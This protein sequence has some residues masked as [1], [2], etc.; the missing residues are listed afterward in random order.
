LRRGDPLAGITGTAYLGQDGA[1]QRL[2]QRALSREELRDAIF[3]TPY[4]RMPYRAY[5]ERLAETCAVG[6][7]PTKAE[8]EARL[9]EIRSVRL[10]TLNYCPMGCTFCSS[11][12][13]LHSAQEGTARLA[14]LTAEECV[15]ML[16]RILAAHPDARTLI[17]QD[18]IFAFRNDARLL[19]LCEALTEC[20]RRVEIPE[21]FSF[22]STNRIDAMTDE[23]LAAMRGAGFR[24]LGFGV[25]NFSA[26]VLQEF[27]K[28]QIR[29]HI[30]PVLESALRLGITPFL[31][32]IL[33]SPRC[34]LRD[35]AA[36]VREARAWIV[37]GCEI[38]MY[39]YVIPFAGAPMASDPELRAHTVY[40]TRHVQGTA[41]SWEQPAKILPLDSLVRSAILLIESDFQER[42]SRIRGIRHLPSRLRSLLWIVCAIP[43]LR[44]MGQRMPSRKGAVAD[45]LVRLSRPHQAEFRAAVR[46]AS[47]CTPVPMPVSA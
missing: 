15:E 32:M 26:A 1:M 19:P 20:K 6:E 38:G 13:F 45:L 24:V 3:R 21:Y 14:R 46:P 12:N 34:S 42:L 37:S 41:L 17:F 36:N 28:A 43:V 27:N 5:W 35:L 18:D 30:K 33:T 7:L 31:D 39:P 8:R 40:A 25:E 9:A 44:R 2:P 47:G 29:P 16:R 10:I 23:R 4:E 11:T 22:I